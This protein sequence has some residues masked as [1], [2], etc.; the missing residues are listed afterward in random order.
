M[1]RLPIVPIQPTLVREPFHRPVAA[2]R[3]RRVELKQ[4]QCD[5]AEGSRGIV[6]VKPSVVAE[7]QYNELMLGRLRDPVLRRLL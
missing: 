4:P 5:G 2:L 7:V 1:T 6:W 3:E